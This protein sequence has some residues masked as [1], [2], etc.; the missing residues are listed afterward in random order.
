MTVT[1]KSL[2]NGQ[3][4]SSKGDLYE[5]PAATY[6]IVNSITLVN[7]NSTAETINIYFKA[8]GGTS[9]LVSPKNYSL[10]ANAWAEVLTKAITMEAAD[11]LEGSTTTG[12]KVDFVISGVENS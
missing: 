12:S 3:L 9:R 1:I 8:S 10:A 11:K 2:A 5:T 7:T 6:T 4:A